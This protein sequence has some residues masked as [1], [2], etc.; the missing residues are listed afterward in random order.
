MTDQPSAVAP[1]PAGPRA[2]LSQSRTLK[3]AALAALS[4]VLDQIVDPALAA[5]QQIAQTTQPL[6]SVAPMFHQMFV[7]S[8]LAGIVLAVYA[9]WDDHRRG[10]R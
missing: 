2:D 5:V 4:T 10:L 3:G 6:D 1:D 9:R 8:T 7:W